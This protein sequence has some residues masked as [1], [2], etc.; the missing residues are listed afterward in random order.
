MSAV[1]LFGMA[2]CSDE[3]LAKNSAAKAG[4]LIHFSIDRPSTRTVYETSDPLQ[5]DWIKG[6]Q[7]K[8]F[9]EQAGGE[10]SAVYS[11]TP[12]SDKEHQNKLD[13]EGAQSKYGLVD[14]N[15]EGLRWNGALQNN[16]GLTHD[17]F[18]VYPADAATC[19]ADGIAEFTVNTSQVCEVSTTLNDDGKTGDAST[20]YV[21]APHMENA[22]MVAA[23]L[24]VSASTD[25]VNLVFAP[26]MTTLNIT[27]SANSNGTST[28]SVNVTGVTVTVPNVPVRVE[29]GKYKFQYM[30]DENDMSTAC[31]KGLIMGAG[32][33]M[34]EQNINVFAGVRF[35]RHNE[36]DGTDEVFNSIPL[37]KGQSITFTVFLPP[38]DS[39]NF[40]DARIRVNASGSANYSVEVGNPI[41][42][43]SKR[44]VRLPSITIGGSS[45]TNEWISELDDDIYI[46]QLSIPGTTNSCG[47]TSFSNSATGQS[48][49]LKAQWAAGVRAFELRTSVADVG[50]SYGRYTMVCYD[51]GVNLR[52]SFAAAIDSIYD[53]VKNTKE[54]A[55]VLLSYNAENMSNLLGNINRFWKG[56]WLK[57]DNGGS[58]NRSHGMP[59]YIG[60]NTTNGKA[61]KDYFVE[62]KPELTI[63]EARSKIILLNMDE[64]D[65][66]PGALINGA[67][68]TD[69]SGTFLGADTNTS[70]DGKDYI[71][72]GDWHDLTYPSGTMA[73]GL[74]LQNAFDR[75]YGDEQTHADKQSYIIAAD[76]EAVQ[77]ASSTVTNFPWVINFVGGAG[78]SGSS[79][80]GNYRA[81]AAA[82][83]LFF[84][85]WLTG[86][87]TYN[88]KKRAE[89]PTGIVMVSHQGVEYVTVTTTF[90]WWSST[91]Q[92]K[93]YGENLPQTIINNNF[94][95][96]LKRK[97]A[98]AQ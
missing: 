78:A 48:K 2:S 80:T 8:I 68:S 19:D 56:Y 9:C 84:N 81:S 49:S 7:I 50:A 74:Y 3:D 45:R 22:Y 20:A 82:N 38:V 24:G 26:V 67:E 55:I 34:T 77:L 12:T 52:T 36:S 29:D 57:E 91:R 69:R 43:S 41:K 51:G 11:I 18:A 93:V 59:Y 13:G 6:D 47:H 15:E 5:I 61:R 25:K 21:A 60:Q 98:S 86:E 79:S 70:A 10:K 28:D 92:V 35:T 4:Q 58:V 32:T 1:V 42:P 64:F 87:L 23:D 73:K 31:N 53:F 71:N 37:A 54:F 89:G 97:P 14:Y 63:K 44:N 62:F 27:V 72:K 85:Q 94:K 96:P 39:L 76:N 33:G 95:F 65:G 90:L 17:F 66:Y 75:E 16:P 40:E 88:G 46:N 30:I 83:N